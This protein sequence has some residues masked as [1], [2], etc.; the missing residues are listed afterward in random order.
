M[1]HSQG[2]LENKFVQTEHQCMSQ[3]TH[4]QK[5]SIFPTNENSI[6]FQKVLYHDSSLHVVNGCVY[7]VCN[8]WCMCVLCIH[9][10]LVALIGCFEMSECSICKLVYVFVYLH[11][12]V[13]LLVLLILYC[14]HL[15]NYCSYSQVVGGPLE[16]GTYV[17]NVGYIYCHS[18]YQP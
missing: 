17:Y 4:C 15:Y 18:N 7:T 2:L 9:V 6:R 11:S 14:Q 3:E 1:G 8:T 16:H 13:K 5:F 10:R 12:C